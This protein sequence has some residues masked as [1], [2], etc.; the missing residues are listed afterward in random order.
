MQILFTFRVNGLTTNYQ[1]YQKITSPTLQSSMF[2]RP[3]TLQNKKLLKPTLRKIIGPTAHQFD[4]IT[5]PLTTILYTKLM[6]I[7]TTNITQVEV[8]LTKSFYIRD[9]SDHQLY[10]IKDRTDYQL[11]QIKGPNIAKIEG[12]LLTTNFTKLKVPPI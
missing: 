8:L 2:Y 5:R 7:L 6:V 4:K 11:Y 12:T 10:I 1:I 3:Q 9:R